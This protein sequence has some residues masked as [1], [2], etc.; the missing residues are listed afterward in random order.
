M[1]RIVVFLV[2]SYQRILSPVLPPSCRFYPSCSDYSLEALE[3][4]GVFRG[5]YLTARRLLCCHPFH[6]GGFDPLK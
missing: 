2:K 4:Y 1:K 5:L 3:R 6:A